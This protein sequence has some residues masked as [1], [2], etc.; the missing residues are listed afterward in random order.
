MRYSLDDLKSGRL[1]GARR[2]KI[3]E[4]LTEVPRDIFNLAE[5][6]EI[7]DLS[8]NNIKALPDDFARLSKLQ[9]LFLSDNDFTVFPKVLA[10]CPALTM[11]GFK[12]NKIARLPEH[13]LPMQTRWLILTDNKLTH[14]PD[15]IGDLTHL[16][17]L[18]L[19][20]NELQ[21]LPSSFSNCCAL[22]LLRISAN[23]LSVFPGAVLE[24]PKLAWLAFSGNPFCAPFPSNTAL[25]DVSFDDIS[26]GEV[27]GA[28]ASGIITRADWVAAPTAIANPQ[29]P[30]AVKTFKGAVT[31]DGYPRDE[32][33]ASLAAGAHDGLIPILAKIT[34][35]SQTGLA[36]RLI[37]PSFINLGQPPNFET[38][39]RDVFSDT[40]SFSAAQVLNIAQSLSRIM[41]H[42]RGRHI[43]HGDLYAHNILVNEGGEILLGDFGAASNYAALNPAQAD[44]LEAIEVRAFGCFL[45]DVISVTDRD[46]SSENILSKLEILAQAC[47]QSNPTQRPNFDEIQERFL[48]TI[49]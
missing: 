9:I 47:L 22:E 32:L 49:I 34:S 45:E 43:C 1:V 24:L 20:G 18:M 31:S 8:G 15:S 21:S 44:A 17:K 38:C 4:G 39:T 7:L 26:R 2:V 37:D 14:L 27:L 11:I 13:A 40:A 46:P 5:T 42:L 30:I 36:M 48:G 41:A 28:G 33:A 25:P 6:L 23:Q 19:A 16:R 10:Q 35:G 3:S 29:E 12:A